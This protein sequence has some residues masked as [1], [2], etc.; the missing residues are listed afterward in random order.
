[1]RRSGFHER[2]C[3]FWRPMG[4]P[5]AFGKT[6]SPIRR[7]A[8]FILCCLKATTA[9]FDSLMVRFP[10][11]VFGGADNALVHAAINPESTAVEVNVLPL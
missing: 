8:V 6:H 3:K 2:L 7:L 4:V 11:L 5:L 9:S 10:A 1:M